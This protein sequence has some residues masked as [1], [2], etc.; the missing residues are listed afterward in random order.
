MED[1]N[2]LQSLLDRTAQDIAG[3]THDPGEWR[4]SVL[5]LMKLLESK[6]QDRQAFE[7]ML[8]N[9]CE[10]LAIRVD[11]ARWPW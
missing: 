5:Y 1:F 4:G 6:S 9:L 3:L 8:A 10:D 2:D 7:A 11:G